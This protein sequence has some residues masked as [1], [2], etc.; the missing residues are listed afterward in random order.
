MEPCDVLR[1]AGVVAEAAAWRALAAA[2]CE[3]S[4]AGEALRQRLADW[5][6]DEADA[7]EATQRVR[8]ATAD[9][10]ACYRLYAG[11]DRAV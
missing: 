7:S 3:A 4:Q 10:R 1:S 8:L 9:L 6:I 11:E 2:I 5:P